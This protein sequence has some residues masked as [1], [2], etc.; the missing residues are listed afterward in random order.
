MITLAMA[1]RLPDPG[2]RAEGDGDH[3][4]DQH[5]GGH[6]D[7]PQAHVVGLQDGGVARHALGAQRVGVVDL[8]DAVL[9]D[10]A[11]QHEEAEHAVDVE[12]LVE[13][14][15]ATASANGIDSG[16]ASRIVIGWTKL[17]NC[18]ARIMYMKTKLSRKASRKLVPVSPSDLARPPKAMP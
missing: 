7:R 17:S 18:A 3:A 5:H 15:A 14:A 16:S 9:L 12:R 1:A 8:Q 13:Q 2:P 6:Q 4:G 10:D 11:E